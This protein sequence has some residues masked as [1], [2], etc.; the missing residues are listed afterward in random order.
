MNSIPYYKIIFRTMQAL[1]AN[2]HLQFAN[3][4]QYSALKNAF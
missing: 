4:L 2:I 1:N 3:I